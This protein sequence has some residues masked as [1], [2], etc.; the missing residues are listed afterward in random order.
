MVAALR[1]ARAWACA[2]YWDRRTPPPQPPPPSTN[3]PGTRADVEAAVE[4][5]GAAHEDDSPVRG[6]ASVTA[7]PAAATSAGTSRPLRRTVRRLIGP[8]PASR[9]AAAR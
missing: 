3:V 4:A 8:P 2:P 7:S 6:S 9:P 1:P 5:A